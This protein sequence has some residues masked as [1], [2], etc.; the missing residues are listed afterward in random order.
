MSSWGLRMS[1]YVKKDGE[2]GFVVL[3]VDVESTLMSKGCSWTQAETQIAFELGLRP[4][5]SIY[6][7]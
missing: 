7:S 1:A 2:K 6:P 3:S 5:G 4:R